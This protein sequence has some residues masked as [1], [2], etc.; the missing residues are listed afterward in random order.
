MKLEL[1]LKV[2]IDDYDDITTYQSINDKENNIKFDVTNLNWNPEDAIIGRALFDAGDY[3]DTLNK[4]IELANKGYT[5]VVV[6][7]VIKKNV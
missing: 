7:K 5:E 3:I 2:E 4:G 6:G 1:N